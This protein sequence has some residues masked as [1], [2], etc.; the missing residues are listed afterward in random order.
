MNVLESHLQRQIE[1]SRRFFWHRLRWHAVSRYLPR[2]VPF[3]L[4]D[5]GAGAGLLG[6]YL[7]EDFPL[8]SYGFVEP[9]RS[10]EIQLEARFGEDANARDEWPYRAEFVTLLDVLEHQQDDRAFLSE[11]VDRMPPGARLILTVPALRRLW[12]SWDDALGHFRRY[13]RRK[14]RALLSGVPVDTVSVDYLF[15]EMLA[16]ALMRK[17]ARARGG[18]GTA[19]FPDLPRPLNAALVG[20]GRVTLRGQGRWPAGTSILAVARRW[21]D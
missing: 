15:P 14:I 2:G 11:L 7:A 21:P 6:E 17:R 13:D 5:V 18:E 3:R 19:E 10:L 20:I 4:V 8:A 12:S 1:H 9:L 16:P